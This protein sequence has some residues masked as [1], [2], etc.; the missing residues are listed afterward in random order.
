MGQTTPAFE[1]QRTPRSLGFCRPRGA[2]DGP[3]R[4]YAR[5]FSRSDDR[6]PGEVGEASRSGNDQRILARRQWLVENEG[7]LCV[8]GLIASA[9]TGQICPD[10]STTSRAVSCLSGTKML[11]T[12]MGAE[13]VRVMLVGLGSSG[14]AWPRLKPT[15]WVAWSW[16]WAATLS[17][18]GNGPPG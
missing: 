4:Q 12:S 1:G 8:V 13:K 2:R 9:V 14:S 7:E 17:S 5:G 15:N 16:G 11:L 3:A 10:E 18:N 6:L